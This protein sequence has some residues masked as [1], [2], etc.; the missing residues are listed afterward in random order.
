[1][2]FISTIAPSEAQEDVRQMYQRQQ[3]Y[4]GYIP[5][6]AKVFSHRPEVLARWARL[7]AEIRRTMEDRLFELATFAAAHELGNSPC[8]LAH[9]KE[10]AAFIG[11]EAV[12]AI[13]A[14]RHEAVLGPA[15]AEVVS[16]AR[17][18][19]RDAASVT[20]ADVDAL[21]A[22]GYDD[23]TIFDIAD[24]VAG[25]AYLTKLLDALGVKPDSAT[26]SLDPAFRDPLTV[27]RPISEEPVERL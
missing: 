19:A 27:G 14:G 1:M 20:Q 24:A 9:G 6:Y 2:A 22:Q 4:W 25:R 7:L 11:E 12:V 15:E 13:A 16:F 17:K 5:G 10:L 18:A 8:S 3:D 21:R 26:R 23:G